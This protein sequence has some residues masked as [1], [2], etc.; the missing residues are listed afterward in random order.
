[1]ISALIKVTFG[2]FLGLSKIYLL[3]FMSTWHASFICSGVSKQKYKINMLS[4]VSYTAPQKIVSTM[5]KR[6]NLCD[7]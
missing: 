1:M 2:F 3:A 4:L 6:T 7:L 5:F